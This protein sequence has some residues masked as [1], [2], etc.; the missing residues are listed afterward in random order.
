MYEWEKV[1]KQQVSAIWNTIGLFIIVN[2][3]NLYP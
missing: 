2:M 1:W 3:A